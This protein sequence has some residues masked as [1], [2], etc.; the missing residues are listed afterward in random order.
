MARRGHSSRGSR[1]GPKNQVWTTILNRNVGILAGATKTGTDIVAPTDWT[2]VG[3]S[4]R[5]TIM[6]IRGWFAVTM[7]EP[8]LAFIGGSAFAYVGLYDEDEVSA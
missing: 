8:V 7:Q 5:A 6:R 1:R 3:G 4:E 2:V